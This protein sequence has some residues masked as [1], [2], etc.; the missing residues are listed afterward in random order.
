M[1]HRGQRFVMDGQKW[2]VEYV[3]E[4]RAHCVGSIR[5]VVTKQD[6]K[7]GTSRTFTV[8]A[9]QSIDISPNAEV[10]GL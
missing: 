4:C 5:R 8:S 1:L 2:R 10:E 3:N 7:T 6:R 9:A